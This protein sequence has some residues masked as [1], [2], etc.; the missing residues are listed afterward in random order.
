[1]GSQNLHFGVIA[2]VLSRSAYGVVPDEFHFAYCLFAA[3]AISGR[4]GFDM[5]STGS[6]LVRSGLDP[7]TFA[8]ILRTQNISLCFLAFSWRHTA[9]YLMNCISL[10]LPIWVCVCTNTATPSLP[11]PASRLWSRPGVDLASISGR[12]RV[13]LG[14]ISGRSRVDLGS[15]W[16]RSGV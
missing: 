13:D 12:S 4:S 16:G 10:L 15:I 14:S 11:P 9:L 7:T 1:M 6:I 2:C 3:G 8:D 5:G